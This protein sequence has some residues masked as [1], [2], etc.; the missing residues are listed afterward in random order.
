MSLSLFT[1]V[2]ALVSAA[3]AVSIHPCVICH[4]FMSYAAVSRPS[5]LLELTL[6]GP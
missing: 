5:R 2:F 4:H 1:I 6:T 3:V